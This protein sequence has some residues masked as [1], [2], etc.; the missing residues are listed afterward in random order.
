MSKVL[1]AP[2]PLGPHGEK[3]NWVVSASTEAIIVKDEN[4]GRVIREYSLQGATKVEAETLTGVGRLV[5]W[6]GDEA[7]AVVSYP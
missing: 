3:V 1:D 2:A 7:T 5:I 4:T 6:Y